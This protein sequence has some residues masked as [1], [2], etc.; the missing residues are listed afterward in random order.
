MPVTP[1]QTRIIDGSAAFVEWAA[2]TIKYNI[3]SRNF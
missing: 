1:G 3:I 2:F